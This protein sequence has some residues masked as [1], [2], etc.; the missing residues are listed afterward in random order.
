MA[1][2]K[3]QIGQEGLQRK[4]WS[5][6]E[7]YRVLSLGGGVDSYAM[8]LGAKL[9]GPK[10]DLV[11]F[12]DVTDPYNAD[13]GEWDSTYRHIIDHVMP[14]CEREGVEF[15][16]LHTDESPIRGERSLIKYFEQKHL[17]PSRTSKMCTS[18]AKVERIHNFINEHVPSLVDVEMWIG[19]EAGEENRGGKDSKDPHAKAKG[20]ITKAFPMQ[21]WGLC[22]CR[23]VDLIK[24]HGTQMPNGSACMMC[25]LAKKDDFQ[26]LRSEEPDVFMRVEQLEDNCRRTKAGKRITFGYKHGDERDLRLTDWIDASGSGPD[27]K[28]QRKVIQ[29]EVCGGDKP[30]K[31]TACNYLN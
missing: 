31:R 14:D 16:W 1:I 30:A 10:P 24:A 21:W 29:C 26:R 18:A 6:T 19:F 20:R 27:G 15:K 12:A 5:A 3:P 8:W 7:P 22:R 17:M 2:D 11:I 23:A 9:W 4:G 28:Y 13:P 25:P